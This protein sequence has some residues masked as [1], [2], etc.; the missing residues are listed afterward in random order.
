MEEKE[1]KHELKKRTFDEDD[2]E[3]H[4]LK[5]KKHKDLHK[6]HIDEGY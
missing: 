4:T 3:K 6:L 5:W 2:L 1:I